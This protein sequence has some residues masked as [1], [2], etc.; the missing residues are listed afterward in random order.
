MR[1][2]VLLIVLVCAIG[3]LGGGPRRALAVTGGSITGTVK[4]TSGNPIAGVTLTTSTNGCVGGGAT[5]TT[6]ADGSYTIGGL[7]DGT[8]DVEASDAGFATRWYPN[9][10]T[11]FG[12]ITIAGGDAHTGIDFAL[13]VGGSITGR[14]T[15]PTNA[16]LP[17]AGA[18][19]SAFN[20]TCWASSTSTAG[21]GTYTLSDLPPTA[22]HLEAGA[23]GYAT[24]FYNKT[25]SINSSS[26]IT[27][28]S[29][30]TASGIDFTLEHAATISGTVTAAA[31]G[32]ISGAE[33]NLVDSTSDDQGNSTQ[34]NGTYTYANVAPGCYTMGASA[35]GRAPAMYNG[36]YDQSA[37][38]A[39]CV[40]AGESRTGVDFALAAES[41]IQGTVRDTHG[42]P[43][44]GAQIFASRP[45]C[46]RLFG[47]GG[48][49]SAADGTYTLSGLDPAAYS[50]SATATG[51][52]G[53][54][55]SG[56]VTPPLGGT[57]T[58]IDVV[59]VQ[60]GTITGKVT[61]QNGTPVAGASVNANPAG[62]C[63]MQPVTTAADGTYTI[64]APVGTYRLLV[65]KTGFGPRYYGGASDERGGFDVIVSSAQTTP[66]IDVSLEP[67]GTI[68]GT[69]RDTSN[70]AVA[71]ATVYAQDVVGGFTQPVQSTG[72]GAYAIHDLAPGTYLMTA[73]APGH[74]G[75]YYPNSYTQAGATALTVVSGGTLSGIDLA[76][77]QGA[78]ISGRVTDLQNNPLPGVGV[79]A[80]GSA[81]TIPQFFGGNSSV[82]TAAD[83]T[84]TLS[85]IG[86]GENTLSF[87]DG[88]N[89][90]AN[91]YYH[92][93][94]MQAQATQ[95]TTSIG[96]N[97]TGIDQQLSHSTGSV[98]GTVTDDH[99]QPVAGAAVCADYVPFVD[100]PGCFFVVGS[101]A[102]VTDASG[103]YT[104]TGLAAGSHVI[105]AA[106]PGKAIQFWNEQPSLPAAN[107]VVSEGGAT[108]NVDFSLAPQGE[109][110]GIVVDSA[111]HKVSNVAAAAKQGQLIVAFGG[112]QPGKAAAGFTIGNLNT[113]DYQL[114]AFI[115]GGF[116]EVN[117]H[118]TAGSTTSGIVLNAGDDPDQ[119]L[120]P[121]AIDNCPDAHNPDQTDTDHDGYGD[122]C[123]PNPTTFCPIMRADVDDSGGVSLADL[124]AVAQVFNRAV[125]PASARL[126]QNADGK[127]N[128]PDLSLVAKVFNRSVS[129]CP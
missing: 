127:I 116:N 4:D 126:D 121:A 70:A 128:L 94:Y 86:P 68:T 20:F 91:V 100:P 38:T 17:V 28:T 102:A 90:Y 5:A 59:L 34:A 89:G 77:A 98:S 24:Q 110:A 9:T 57:S 44:A 11:S 106:A 30:G 115:F 29:G 99:G 58:G 112:I 46:P 109:I 82:A 84:F 55:Y 108:P 105:T 93:A 103:N 124:A 27:P 64:Q 23:N 25:Y 104:L 45:C 51:Y 31:G 54:S 88:Q 73:W 123:D 95:V 14:A 18:F 56:T 101:P 48:A 75:A 53:Q 129:A 52:V 36:V 32:A 80:S 65:S 72:G 83:G 21:D 47:G 81:F 78:T 10:Y 85:G 111:G 96:E 7:P 49:T 118:V 76:L 37:S 13:E 6:G 39:V 122:A 74:S 79:S 97:V 35:A 43:I 66:N 113:G 125:P 117:V 71:G 69:I 26:S 40:T 50:V 119:D 107:V 22:L 42:A 8:Y 120:V 62:S 12:T 114:A 33:L 2:V 61:D 15:D 60:D 67:G 87:Q 19:V 63:C 16:N 3:A 41:R 92:G 1:R